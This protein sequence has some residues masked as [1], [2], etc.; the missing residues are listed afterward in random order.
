MNIVLI[1]GAFMSVMLSVMLLTKRMRLLS[2]IL[3]SIY[4]IISAIILILAFFEIENRASDYAHPSLINSSTPFVLLLGPM[5]WMYVRSLVK[6]E[7]KLQLSY[8]F[9]LL[10]FL[11]VSTLLFESNY[12][13]PDEIRIALDRSESFKSGYQFPVIVVLIALSN[14]GYALW[15]LIDLKKFSRKIKGYFSQLEDIDLRWL[16]FIIT[17]SLICHTAISLLYTLDAIFHLMSYNTLQT[18]GFS[19]ASTFVIVIGFFGLREGDLF[20]SKRRDP[21]F[22]VMNNPTKDNSKRQSEL[23]DEEELFIKEFINFMERDK[24]FLDPDL[25]L[26]KLAEKRSVSAEYLSHILNNRLNSNFYDLI[27][28]YRVDEFKRLCKEPARRN[29]TIIAIAYDSG[30]NSKATFNRVFKNVTGFTPSVYY[31]ECCT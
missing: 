23:T 4:L 17:L 10:P 7:F 14:F 24:P 20:A 30:F 21:Q 22:E 3:L 8:L 6:K 25:T 13:S 16:S 15:A 27:N 5:L 2:D 29:H 12:S 18:I 9:M 1:I 26:S 11:F 28:R 31:R 19:I